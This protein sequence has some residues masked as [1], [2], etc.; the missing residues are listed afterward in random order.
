MHI[1]HS[2]SLA[3]GSGV[4]ARERRVLSNSGESQEFSALCVSMG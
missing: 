2:R 4:A 1:G 3:A